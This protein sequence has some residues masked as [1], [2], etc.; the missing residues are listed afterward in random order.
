MLER[1]V[2][3]KYA[4]CTSQRLKRTFGARVMKQFESFGLGKNLD[5]IKSRNLGVIKSRFLA[6]R[7]LYEGILYLLRL[8]SLKI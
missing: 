6:V 5:L 8:V 1:L 7:L 3:K 4:E 2:L